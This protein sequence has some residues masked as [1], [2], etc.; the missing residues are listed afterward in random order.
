[1][2][3]SAHLVEKGL[4][5]CLDSE[6]KDRLLEKENGQFNLAVKVEENFKKAVDLNKK[7]IAESILIALKLHW[8]S[9]HLALGFI[10]RRLW[11]DTSRIFLLFQHN[12]ADQWQRWWCSLIARTRMCSVQSSSI[13]AL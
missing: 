8:I 5:V 6:F 4:N 1:M 13:S 2:K 3:I 10:L 12:V 9:A 11:L 7:T